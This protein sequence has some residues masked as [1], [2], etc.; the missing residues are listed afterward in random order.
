M[1]VCYRDAWESTHDR[2]SGATFTPDNPL[3]RDKIVKGTKP[4]RDWPFRRIDYFVRF[5]AHGGRAFDI[6]NCERILH[7]GQNESWASDHFGL[8]TDLAPPYVAETV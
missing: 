5:G 7:E 8:V 1:S 6:V 4:F 3:V 2:D